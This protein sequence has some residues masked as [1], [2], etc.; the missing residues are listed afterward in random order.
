MLISEEARDK[1]PTA[2]HR[3]IFMSNGKKP[4]Q[5]TG[6]SGG[7]FQE[8]G[9]K[10]GLRP[11]FAAVSDNKPLPPTSKPNSTWKPVLTTPNS[12]KR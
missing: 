1:I 10:G 12:K 6:N 2:Q 8:Q 11:N 4:G 9:P 3:S 7:V 5:N